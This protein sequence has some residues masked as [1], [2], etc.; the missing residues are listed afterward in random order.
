MISELPSLI[1]NPTVLSI[2]VYFGSDLNTDNASYFFVFLSISIVLTFASSTYGF[3]IG[4][5]IADKRL[6]AGLIPVLV[7]PQMLFSGFFVNQDNMPNF[8]IPFEHIS[9]FKYGYQAYVQN[10]F[11]DITV[12]CSDR[13][14]PDDINLGQNTEVSIIILAA[15]GIFWMMV[16]YLIL[17]LVAKSSRK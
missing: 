13:N 5:I 17:L 15:L 1:I 10:E 7:I 6:A 12:N 16:S 9:L 2:I 8:L 14:P 3:T 11:D 4:S